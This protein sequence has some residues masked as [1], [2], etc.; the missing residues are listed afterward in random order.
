MTLLRSHQQPTT[1]A[2]TTAAPHLLCHW[3][4]IGL[5]LGLCSSQGEGA[6]FDPLSILTPKKKTTSCLL[7]HCFSSPSSFDF[8]PLASRDSTRFLSIPYTLPA[9]VR[10]A[11]GSPTVSQVRPSAN[12]WM[13]ESQSWNTLF[14]PH[15][16][17][18][19][20]NAL[21]PKTK[22]PQ[23]CTPPQSE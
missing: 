5:L 20:P 14:S 19:N 4:L 7:F 16:I 8:E 17:W 15:A 12:F 1:A 23:I 22:C 11:R 10:I 21:V 3:P 13:E 9:P 18:R 2:T 6:T